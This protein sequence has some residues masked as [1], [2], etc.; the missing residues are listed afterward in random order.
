MKHR[1][2]RFAFTAFFLSSLAFADNPT[3]A[4]LVTNDGSAAAV[5][6]ENQEKPPSHKRKRSTKRDESASSKT[7]NENLPKDN[8]QK[9]PSNPEYPATNDNSA[10]N[11]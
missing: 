8:R 1:A 6:Q 11:Y 10:G 2:I 5:Q 9:E 3:D 4:P 7:K